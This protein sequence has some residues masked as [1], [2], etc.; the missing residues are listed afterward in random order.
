MDIL[1]FIN[2]LLGIIVK[3]RVYVFNLYVYFIYNIFYDL[4]KVFF[5]YIFIINLFFESLSY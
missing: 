5:I 3:V 4:Y 2:R 1:S